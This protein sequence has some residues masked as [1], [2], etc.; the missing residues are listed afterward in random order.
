MFKRSRFDHAENH[1]PKQMSYIDEW[2]A[3]TVKPARFYDLQSAP[4][5]KRKNYF[6]S[7]D[8]QGRVFLEEVLPKNIATSLKN[9]KFL[10]FF[11][12]HVKRVGR[13]ERAVLEKIG[14]EWGFHSLEEDYPFVSPCGVELNFLRPA[15]TAIVFH[16]MRESPSGGL[17]LVFG[18]TLAQPFSPRRLFI[19]KKTGRIYHELTTETDDFGTD[20]ESAQSEETAS[21]NKTKITPLHKSFG[22][23]F[24]LIKSS[25]AVTLSDEIVDAEEN[26][27]NEENLSGGEYSGMDFICAKNGR[28]SP[29]TW[30]PDGAEPGSWALPP[31][32]VKYF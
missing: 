15:D 30:L 5:L 20:G 24:G 8:L 11:Y 2:H 17:E 31:E 9:E 16:S 12:T 25:L 10:D 6:Y 29:I 22:Q 23:E 26:A 14:E 19:S 1:R 28:R 27:Y 21:K 18:G 4:G 13:K 3:T 32:D 7:V